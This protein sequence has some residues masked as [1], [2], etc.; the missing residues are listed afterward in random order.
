MLTTF[1]L[2]PFTPAEE[3][4]VVGGPPHYFRLI[5][6]QPN[7][8]FTQ[9]TLLS[10]KLQIIDKYAPLNFSEHIF[11]RVGEAQLGLS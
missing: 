7:E 11:A 9:H 5:N 4:A 3:S 6:L 1:D 10:S 2:S 8:I